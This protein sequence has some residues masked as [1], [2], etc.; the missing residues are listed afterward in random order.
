MKKLISLLFMTLLGLSVQA[1]DVIVKHDGSTILSKVIKIGTTEV[2]YKKF[3]NQ[4]GPTYTIL[5]SDIQAINYENGDK[6]TFNEKKL[7]AEEESTGKQQIIVATSAADN[8]EI[9]C[10]YNQNYEH[11]KAIKDGMKKDAKYG[12]CILG[13]GE[14]S[15]LS[16]E[17][18]TVEF[19]QEPYYLFK[20]INGS[21]YY[22]KDRF[23]VQLYNK[24]DKTIYVDLGN[25]FRVMKDGTSYVYY[26]SSQTMITSGS[27]SGV[28]ANLGA[29]VGAIGAGGGLATLANGV[30]V[31]GGNTTSTT[32]TYSKERVIAIPAHGKTPIEKYEIARTKYDDV[33]ISEGEKLEYKYLKGEFPKISKGEC[34]YY[35]EN[36]S[37]YH[38]DYMITYSKDIKFETSYVVKAS[39]YMRE[40][41][42]ASINVS[43]S[44]SSNHQKILDD[45]KEKIPNYNDY[46]IVGT[47]WQ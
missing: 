24:T 16:T 27:G 6:D 18:I 32:K 22:I 4:N 7:V 31:G 12:L 3:S 45:M 35:N 43:F 42:G 10:R 19:R 15:V 13:V 2:E 26:N 33:I 44:I 29:I 34:F 9:I 23:Y 41:I 14:R 20:A 39:V 36:D 40:L 30:S 21:K 47:I 28:S 5:K 25:T 38:V 8:A 11:G 46:T 37:P 1:Q 17:D